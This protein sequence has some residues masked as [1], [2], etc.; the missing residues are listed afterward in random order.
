[1]EVNGSTPFGL[2]AQSVISKL[3]DQLVKNI[4]GALA[5]E[6]IE[7]LHDARVASRRL[8][9]ALR[10]FRIALPKTENAAVQG[11]VRLITQSLGQ[12]R[13]QDVFLG[14]LQGYAADHPD[15]DI[16]WLI[17]REQHIREGARLRMLDALRGIDD[18]VL[19]ANVAAM[20][21]GAIMTDERGRHAFARQAPRLTKSR[22]KE[23][24]ATLPALENPQDISGHHAARIAAKR[25]RYTMEAFLPCFGDPLND[26]I[27]KVKLLQERLGQVHDCD[28]WLDKLEQY[29]KERGLSDERLNA[30]V[31]LAA[32][33]VAARKEHYRAARE[34]WSRKKTARFGRGLLRLVSASYAKQKTEVEEVNAM[35]ESTTS[36]KRATRTTTPKPSAGKS[37][38]GKAAP[39]QPVAKRTAEVKP[40]A[41]PSI[42][43]GLQTALSTVEAGVNTKGAADPKFS[44]Q[45]G[46]LEALLAELPKQMEGLKADAKAKAEKLLSKATGLLQSVADKGE[47]S[48]DGAD[49]A[50]RK[51]RT[52]RKDI[53]KTIGR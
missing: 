41:E 12:V 39:T 51:L 5:G 11:Q 8:R 29:Q 1:M 9:A 10:V 40:A 7:A 3:H 26:Q 27:A 46:K 33:R 47:F 44:K 30:I 16:E 50:R 43:E 4:P 17:L 52:I 22:L 42:L 36:A 15:S 28:V 14:F 25:L 38:A 35:E 20:L 6:D 24:G 23:I 32:N 21:D 18:R 37:A 34:Q 19:A 13:D 49:K 2:A 45:L 48:D 31:Q 53:A